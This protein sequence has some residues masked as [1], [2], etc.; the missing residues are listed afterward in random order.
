MDPELI[1]LLKSAVDHELAEMEE[2][3]IAALEDSE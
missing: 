2:E 1:S 3:R